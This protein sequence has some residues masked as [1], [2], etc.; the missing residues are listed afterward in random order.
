MFGWIKDTVS[1]ITGWL[2]SGIASLF[3][4]LLGGLADIFTA[5]VDAAN[6]FWDVLDGLWDFATGFKASL[7]SLVSAFFPF[8]PASVMTVISLGL[9]VVLIA[10]IVKKVRKE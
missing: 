2:G 10:G 5:I 8:I 7:F 4:W 3:D 1:S 6:A 9:L